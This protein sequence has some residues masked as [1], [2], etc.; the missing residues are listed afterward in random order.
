MLF[1]V[2]KRIRKKNIQFSSAVFP[3][4]ETA[5]DTQTSSVRIVGDLKNTYE[6]WHPL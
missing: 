2:E 4:P 1:S 3:F 5:H 6:K